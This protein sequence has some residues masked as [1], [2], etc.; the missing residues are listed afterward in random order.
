M[1]SFLSVMHLS[2]SYGGDRVLQDVTLRFPATGFIAIVGHP[3]RGRAPFY[4]C[5]PA[6]FSRTRAPCSPGK[7]N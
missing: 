6:R 5:F 2:K 3:V 1:N 7:R 4:P